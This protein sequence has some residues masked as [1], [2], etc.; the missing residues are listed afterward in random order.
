[1]FTNINL[2]E[3]LDSDQ[4]PCTRVIYITNEKFNIGNGMNQKILIKGI[5]DHDHTRLNEILMNKTGMQFNTI[6][7][8]S[9]CEHMSCANL[10]DIVTD[11]AG[12]LG[13]LCQNML[14]QIINDVG[15]GVLFETCWYMNFE[16]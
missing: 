11:D 6:V 1:M 12:K 14:E 8:I 5:A 2:N 3:I 15:Y 13:D 4:R 9:Q 10:G 7:E 16:T